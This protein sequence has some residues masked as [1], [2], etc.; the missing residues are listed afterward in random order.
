MK[1]YEVL[2]SNRIRL[3]ININYAELIKVAAKLIFENPFLL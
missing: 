1:K 2:E 3:R